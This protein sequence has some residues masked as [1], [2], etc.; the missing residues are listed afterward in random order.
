[1]VHFVL[2][3]SN[4]TES[5]NILIWILFIFLFRKRVIAVVVANEAKQTEHFTICT[6]LFVCK[7]IYIYLQSCSNV[8]YWVSLLINRNRN[9]NN[10]MDLLRW[11]NI[12]VPAMAHT[13]THRHTQIYTYIYIQFKVSISIVMWYIPFFC[14]FLFLQF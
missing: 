4:S 1:M 11:V 10:C 7:L 3:S 8:H 9:R 12:S 6:C 13:Q 2:C 14:F 5:S